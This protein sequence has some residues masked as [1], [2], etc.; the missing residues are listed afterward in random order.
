MATFTLKLFNMCFSELKTFILTH[1]HQPR[2]MHQI[3]PTGK[4]TR[5]TLSS[6]GKK[7]TLIKQHQLIHSVR[8]YYNIMT[9]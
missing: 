8:F 2:P 1:S 6:E 9:H 5:A 7:K 4:E 3:Q